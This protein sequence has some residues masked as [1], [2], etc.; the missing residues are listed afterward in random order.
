MA[1]LTSNL[2]IEPNTASNSGAD[3]TRLQATIPGLSGNQDLAMHVIGSNTNNDSTGDNANG[4][5]DNTGTNIRAGVTLQIDSGATVSA[6]AMYVRCAATGDGG[7]LIL[8]NGSSLSLGRLTAEG[9]AGSGGTQLVGPNEADLDRYPTIDI[10]NGSNINLTGSTGQNFRAFLGNWS[11]GRVLCRDRSSII[12]DATNAS[13]FAATGGGNGARANLFLGFHSE[14]DNCLLKGPNKVELLGA[15]PVFRDVTLEFVADSNSNNQQWLTDGGPGGA[16]CFFLAGAAN[17]E[18]TLGSHSV[19][20]PASV[21]L[22]PTSGNNSFKYAVIR[23]QSSIL[24]L[25]G[26]ITLTHGSTTYPVYCHWLMFQ[27]QNRDLNRR[28]EYQGTL[29]ASGSRLTADGAPN[30]N[31]NGRFGLMDNRD[32][33]QI[34]HDTDAWTAGAAPA[35]TYDWYNFPNHSVTANDQQTAVVYGFPSGIDNK[36]FGIVANDGR[37]SARSAARFFDTAASNST[38]VIS[39]LSNVAN[40]SGTNAVTR[41]DLRRFY[42]FRGGAWEW[43]HYPEYINSGLGGTAKI[44]FVGGGINDTEAR[45]NH[46]RTADA[47]ANDIR[48]GKSQTFTVTADAAMAGITE[49][50][51][52]AHDITHTVDSDRQVLTINDAATLD[53][54]YQSTQKWAYDRFNSDTGAVYT[55]TALTSSNR[56]ASATIANGVTTIASGRIG[57][58]DTDVVPTGASTLANN[59]AWS[60]ARSASLNGVTFLESANGQEH[61]WLR[62]FIYCYID[63]SN[64]ALYSFTR[65][66]QEEDVNNMEHVHLTHIASAGNIGSTAAL[67]LQ[68]AE[69]RDSLAFETDWPVRDYLW[70]PDV[71]LRPAESANNVYNIRRTQWNCNDTDITAGTRLD[72][73]N[74]LDSESS[75]VNCHELNVTVAGMGTISGFQTSASGNAI[76]E[77]ST[78]GAGTTLQFNGGSTYLIAGNISNATLERVGSGNASIIYVGNGTGPNTATNFNITKRVSLTVNASHSWTTA[79]LDS[80][81]NVQIAAVSRVSTNTT[82]GTQRTPETRTVNGSAVTYNFTIP[83]TED[84]YFAFA[85]RQAGSTWYNIVEGNSV[86]TLSPSVTLTTTLTSV[87]PTAPSD[88]TGLDT[89][90][91]YIIDTDVVEALSAAPSSS[92]KMQITISNAAVAGALTDG[93]Y[94]SRLVQQKYNYLLNVARAYTILNMW[95]IGT[96]RVIY[97]DSNVT[98]QKASSNSNIVAFAVQVLSGAGAGVNYTITTTDNG[99]AVLWNGP[100]NIGILSQAQADTLAKESSVWA[101]NAAL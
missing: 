9:Q 34:A 95:T 100:T 85:A 36:V 52:A 30:G 86:T 21:N 88:A 39:E 4:P 68:I 94:I 56:H 82:G 13:G 53:E 64:Y 44:G 16:G 78:I 37:G 91:N 1:N 92:D 99:T 18:A 84:L 17:I 7:K 54:I 63:A 70:R 46:A 43:Q 45:V 20:L 101:A 14:F 19:I 79:E 71:S 58:Y 96:D 93:K 62:G 65:T 25:N 28:F 27:A 66:Y 50:A 76:G 33:I 29:N 10:R 55:A 80:E 22:F 74:M 47:S 51:A 32:F 49:S 15:V 26:E 98:W 8:D 40:A 3:L 83:V 89:H 57:F 31:F 60:A 5:F 2:L 97:T 59:S 42:P 69:L 90:I 75:M 35:T 41:A 12:I 24:T 23:E 48:N 87:V 72:T 38:T 73:I 81:E 77:N 67:N 11:K 6:G 61:S